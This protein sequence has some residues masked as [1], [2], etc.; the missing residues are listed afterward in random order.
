MSYV[1]ATSMNSLDMYASYNSPS[2]GFLVWLS[3]KPLLSKYITQQLPDQILMYKPESLHFLDFRVELSE[4]KFRVPHYSDN[5]IAE[6]RTRKP[7]HIEDRNHEKIVW[8]SGL[9]FLTVP[10]QTVTDPVASSPS[11]DLARPLCCSR[12]SLDIISKLM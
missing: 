10:V 7:R 5:F 11:V 1:L 4:G 12:H 8:I 3:H 2:S 6:R 9:V